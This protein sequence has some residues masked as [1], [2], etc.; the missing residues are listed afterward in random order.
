[1]F[2]QNGGRQPWK[3][4][5]HMILSISSLSLINC[6]CEDVR[7]TNMKA[8]TLLDLRSSHQRSPPLSILAHNSMFQDIV[9][10]YCHIFLNMDWHISYIAIS[11]GHIAIIWYQIWHGVMVCIESHIAT[12][13]LSIVWYWYILKAIAMI[14]IWY[15]NGMLWYGIWYGMVWYGMY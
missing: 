4:V 10:S 12:K 1:M 13:W 5:S 15:K 2:Y 9:Q 7:W 3:Y 11:E 6:R 14:K 8:V